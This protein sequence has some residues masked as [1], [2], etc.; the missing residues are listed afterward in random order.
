VNGVGT[1]LISTAMGQTSPGSFKSGWSNPQYQRAS[2]SVG[3]FLPKL[4][5]F[6]GQFMYA[7]N[8]GQ[9][10]LGRPDASRH[11]RDRRQSGAGSHRR[12]RT[13]WPIHCGRAGYTNG[14]MWRCRTQ[15]TV[16][17]LP[18]RDEHHQYSNLGG[19]RFRRGQAV[20]QY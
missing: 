1:S 11:R 18:R 20:R 9:L 17:R 6:Y 3:Y 5:G 7:F 14:L 2:N 16:G 12:Q 10:R 8:E 13:C 19:I 4:G 15:N